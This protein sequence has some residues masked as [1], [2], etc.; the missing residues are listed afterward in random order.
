[1]AAHAMRMVG[2]TNGCDHSLDQQSSVK[3]WLI[4]RS[5][6][7]SKQDQAI[8]SKIWRSKILIAVADGSTGYIAVTT[9]CSVHYTISAI[10]NLYIH[11]GQLRDTALNAE[12]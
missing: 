3:F 6:G 7:A 11:T 5:R 9:P 2:V 8:K 10:G 12:K 1:M 4:K